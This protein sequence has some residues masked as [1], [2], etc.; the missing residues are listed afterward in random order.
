MKESIVNKN[1]KLKT[2]LTAEAGINHNGHMDLAY[3]LIDMTA[4]S[5]WDCIKFQK[6]DLDIV[7][8]KE[9]LNTLRK[10]PFG[11][12]N[13][14]LKEHLEFSLNDYLCISDYCKEKDVQW[15]VSPW[16]CKSLNSLCEYFY[17]EIPYIKIASAS[18]TDA[19]LLKEACKS[20]KPLWISTGMC[21]LE[22]IKQII[23]FVYRN[24]GKIGMLF[25]CTSV[26]PTP[27]NQ[28]NLL[29]IKTLQKEFPLVPIGYSGHE[30]GIYPSIAAVVLGAKAIERHITIDKE[31]FGSDQKASIEFSEMYE[32]FNAVSDIEK[33]YGDG[34]IIIYE[35]EKPIIK[36]LRR[37]DNFTRV[38]LSPEDINQKMSV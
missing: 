3:R 24:D 19:E 2:Y 9:E 11:L 21:D 32:L 12:T 18:V 13:R 17:D 33:S 1:P 27:C 8:T 36:K 38:F 22:L 23:D 10:T 37:V 31:L 7:Y 20:R 14:Q 5:G 29:G 6:R 30:Y 26:Y 16:D 25:H 15:T 35:E 28:I 4:N 34:N